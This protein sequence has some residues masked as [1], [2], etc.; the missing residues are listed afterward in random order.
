MKG[1]YI[2]VALSIIWSIV[3]SII[4]K[5]KAAEKAAA[6]KPL[7]TNVS[8]EWK[9]DP[10]KIKIESLRR[11][12]KKSQAQVQVPTQPKLEPQ[13]QTR[14]NPL[15]KKLIK[16]LHY[17]SC[18]LPPVQQARRVNAPAVQLAVMLQKKRNIRTAIVLNEILSKPVSMRR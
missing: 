18:P 12:N 15:S 9:A 5:K 14:I 13:A 17:E 6:S 3:A 4:E 11:R 8:A 2:M 10:V 16:S 1:V 7:R